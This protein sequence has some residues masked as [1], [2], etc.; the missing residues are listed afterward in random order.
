MRTP[1]LHKSREPARLVPWPTPPQPWTPRRSQ[2]STADV[3]NL[4]VLESVPQLWPAPAAASTWYG[5]LPGI[6][7]GK[8]PPRDRLPDFAD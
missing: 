3:A 7:A 5:T 8:R 1:S 6:M 4:D 2:L